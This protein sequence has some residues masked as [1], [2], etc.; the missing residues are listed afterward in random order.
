MSRD[1][2]VVRPLVV[3]PLGFE[4]RTFGL[5][6]RI[7]TSHATAQVSEV[8]FCL[9]FRLGRRSSL[10]RSLELRVRLRARD[11]VAVRGSWS[12]DLEA[13]SCGGRDRRKVVLVRADDEIAPSQ[14]SF[15]DGEVDDVGDGG[16]SGE[17]ADG[18]SLCVAKRF[19]VAPNEQSPRLR[20]N[21]CRRGRHL[22]TGKQR[23]MACP[24]ATFAAISGDQRARVVGDAQLRALSLTGTR[25]LGASDSLFRPLLGLVQFFRCERTVVALELRDRVEALLDD[26]L[27]TSGRGKPPA[28]RHSRLGCG[29]LDQLIEIGRHGD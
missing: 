2:T 25:P 10:T 6:D 21:G 16:A 20:H 3:R 19:D 23:A 14:G 29:A 15:D 26:E 12:V 8:R 22:A 11:H 9:R 1:I 5:R 7:R 28:V 13:S 17:R 27:L 18:A 24:H 4:P